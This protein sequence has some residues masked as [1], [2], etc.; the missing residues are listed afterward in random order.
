MKKYFLFILLLCLFQVFTS[1]KNDDGITDP[2]DETTYTP[3]ATGYPM[4]NFGTTTNYN[5]VMGVIRYDFSTPTLYAALTVGYAQFSTGVNAG[6][7]SINGFE[8]GQTVSS[9]TTFYMTPSAANPTELLDVPFDGS[10][11]NWIVSGGGG[12]PALSG[13]VSSAESFTLSSPVLNAAVSRS[14]NLQVSWSNPSSARVM[15]M[16]MASGGSKYYIAQDLVDDGSHTIPSSS[17]SSFPAGNAALY[18]IKYKY[19]SING[20]DGKTYI[21]ISEIFKTLSIVL[22]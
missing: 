9:G 8:L 21:M 20:S 4:P 3:N 19:S 17:L 11:H 1:C 10:N 15:I 6:T 14:A 2:G 13:H 12:I 16:L 22:N 5:G 18:I 7:V